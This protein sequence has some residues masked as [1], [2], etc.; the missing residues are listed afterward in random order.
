ML[1]LCLDSCICGATQEFL[2]VGPTDSRWEKF[3][4]A[5][6]KCG[7]HSI[8]YNCIDYGCSESAIT[9]WNKMM[10]SCK[11]ALA[12]EKWVSM[13]DYLEEHS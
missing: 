1:A 11:K 10:A 2:F 7:V 5:C 3:E 9:G 12:E 13:A 6:M 8:D 4:A